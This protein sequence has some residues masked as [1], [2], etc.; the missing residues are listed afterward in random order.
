MSD[1]VSFTS[2]GH[3]SDQV[4]DKYLHINTCGK[5][6]Y[7]VFPSITI[8]P[9][10]RRDYLFL[11]VYSGHCLL[12]LPGDRTQVVEKGNLVLYRPGQ[13]QDYRF[14]N[15]DNGSQIFVHFTGT[16]VEEILKR[17]GLEHAFIIRASHENELEMLLLKM[18]ENFDAFGQEDT[19]YCE[20]LLMAVLGLLGLQQSRP[21][22]DDHAPHHIK[23]L[24]DIIGRIHT[25]PAEAFDLDAWAAQC[26]LTKSY[27]IQLFKKTT[28]MPPYRYL[29]SYRI[30][31]A[32]QLLLFSDLSVSEVGRACGYFDYNYF[33][34]LFKKMEG[35][36]PSQF[37]AGK[38]D[39]N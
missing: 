32:R 27:F 24:N 20:G 4:S 15:E 29:T 7:S 2:F 23:I 9:N 39:V 3:F 25:C 8:R 31:Q 12:T 16:G 22:S 14:S 30:Q 34:R 21:D 19:L 5:L 33:S 26:G 18:V 36:S 1:H 35:V 6:G 37:R 28:G 11:Y 10:G 38:K 17:A 13:P